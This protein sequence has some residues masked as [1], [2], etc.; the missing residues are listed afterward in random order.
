MEEETFAQVKRRTSRPIG[1]SEDGGAIRSK[2]SGS[3]AE[4]K[5][6]DEASGEAADVKGSSISSG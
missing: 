4:D 5:T 3:C 1:G 6:G 2:T